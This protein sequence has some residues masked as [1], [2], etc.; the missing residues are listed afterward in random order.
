M[1]DAR[2]IVLALFVSAMGIPQIGLAAD[3]VAAPDPDKAL[4]PGDTVTFQIVE[5]NNAAVTLRVTDNGF[6]PVP[7][8]GNVPASGKNCTELT[9][10]IKKQL[11][12][13]YRTVTVKLAIDHIA[14]QPPHPPMK[15]SVTGS[16]QRAGLLDVPFG[17]TLTIS[18]AI[19][20]AGSAT[21]YGDL[22]K[23][24]FIRR[25]PDGKTSTTTIVDVRPG[26]K[27]GDISKDVQLQDGDT[28]F[29]PKKWIVLGG[30]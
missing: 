7:Y 8:I 20:K 3:A 10:Q 1:A 30:S 23:V 22:G 12:P 29:V 5:D 25:N 19:A 28:I 18:Q 21:V 26:A 17:E 15:I 11:E 6:L 27:K 14:P 9:A 24:R 4:A 16:V 13:F 2:A